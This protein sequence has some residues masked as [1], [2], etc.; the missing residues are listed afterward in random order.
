MV[1]E[2]NESKLLETLDSVAASL[3]SIALLR[4]IDMFY[5]REDRIALL[6]EY[7]SLIDADH[8]AYADLQR[9]READPERELGWEAR[10]EKY[11]E[12]EARKQNA[13]VIALF[14]AKRETSEQ[15]SRFG[16]KHPLIVDLYRKYPSVGQ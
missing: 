3:E 15:H 5:T 7:R 12:E 6:A 8:A 16:Y 11:G 10:V 2:K 14:E 9:A 1:N 4:A 13:P